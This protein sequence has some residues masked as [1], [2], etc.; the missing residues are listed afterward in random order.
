MITKPINEEEYYYMGM[1]EKIMKEYES[2]TYH[3]VN[4]SE[5]KVG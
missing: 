2:Q 5:T 1:V 4:K 3:I